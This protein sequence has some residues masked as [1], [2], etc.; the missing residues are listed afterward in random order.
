M[1]FLDETTTHKVQRISSIGSRDITMDV[2]DYVGHREIAPLRQDSLNWCRNMLINIC[3]HHVFRVH[4]DTF[5]NRN[6]LIQACKHAHA[7]RHCHILIGIHAHACM[8][9][10]IICAY[11]YMRSSSCPLSEPS[12]Y[13]SSTII[14]DFTLLDSYVLHSKICN[15]INRI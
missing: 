6:T 12:T 3:K 1:A 14:T 11:V 8:C 10:H 9:L 15:M 2:C 7:W 5:M 4:M 13:L